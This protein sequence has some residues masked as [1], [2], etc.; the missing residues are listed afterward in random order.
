ML[1]ENDQ[2]RGLDTKVIAVQGYTQALQELSSQLDEAEKQL[3]VLSAVLVLMAY[4]EVCKMVLEL[5]ARPE[6]ASRSTYLIRGFNNMTIVLCK[7]HPCGIQPCLHR[8]LL[9]Y[10]SQV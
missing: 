5:K 8:Q 4:F 9:L 3:E 2:A 1:G 10:S 6:R 7:Q